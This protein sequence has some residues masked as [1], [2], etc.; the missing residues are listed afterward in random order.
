MTVSVDT[1]PDML[2]ITEVTK[3]ENESKDNNSEQE[4][5]KTAFRIFRKG[6]HIRLECDDEI[7][8]EGMRTAGAIMS[9]DIHGII[10]AISDIDIV[11]KLMSG[12]RIRVPLSH[13]TDKRLTLQCIIINYYFSL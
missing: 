3:C 12:T 7:L 1:A 9:S 6:W 8:L 11:V 4:I 13:I 5:N 2:Q 10:T